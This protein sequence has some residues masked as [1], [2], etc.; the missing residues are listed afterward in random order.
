[1]SDKYVQDI[2]KGFCCW[3]CRLKWK[4]DTLMD[5]SSLKAYLRLF[6]ELINIIGKKEDAKHISHDDSFGKFLSWV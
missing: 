5:A 3:S 2:V 1:M 4:V 6:T